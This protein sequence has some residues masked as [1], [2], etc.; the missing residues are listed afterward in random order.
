[1]N[2]L[3]I[4]R[5]PL[6]LLSLLFV[7]VAIYF[8]I[9][10]GRHG[11]GLALGIIMLFTIVWIPIILNGVI[12]SFVDDKKTAAK[13]RWLASFAVIIALTIWLP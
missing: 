1:L 6:I 8:M 2:N 5:N 3:R 4:L 9:N 13:L 11:F 12:T 7:L 10:S